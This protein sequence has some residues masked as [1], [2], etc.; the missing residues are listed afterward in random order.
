LPEYK[1]LNPVGKGMTCRVHKA[2]DAASGRVVAV[3]ELLPEHRADPKR[4]KG[5]E[6]EAQFLRNLKHDGLVEL[7]GFE[8]AK[9]R[10]ILEFMPACL[11]QAMQQPFHYSR[12][13]QWALDVT[14][15]LAYLHDQGIVHKDIKPENVFLSDSGRAKLGDF[16]FAEREAGMLGR[17]MARFSKPRI[18]GTISYLSPEQVAQKPL[19]T[20]SDI[21]SWG[22]VLY[23][24]FGGQRPFRS[25]QEQV[26]GPAAQGSELSII[27]RIIKD[28][29][30]SLRELN[31]E[32]DK[33]LEW[34]VLQCL[35]KKPG[36]RPDARTL[37]SVLK[38]VQLKLGKG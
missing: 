2:Q 36:E 21:F 25:D 10:M 14:S 16:G 33:E 4:L 12:R 13:L 28:S 18:Q 30:G 22:V 37:M 7:V 23:E 34:V 5:L 8:P 31:G 3:K 24:L 29:P 20:R 38:R 9:C 11:R 32:L 6:Q 19:T 26:R 15:A 1:L 27:R 17:M 35:N